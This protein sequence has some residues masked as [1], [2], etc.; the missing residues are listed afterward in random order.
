MAIIYASHPP[1]NRKEYFT[2]IVGAIV[3][4]AIFMLFALT[5]PAN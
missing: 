5:F 3:I 2:M 4:G 1:K